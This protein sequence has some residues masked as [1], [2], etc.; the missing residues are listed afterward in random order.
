M[1]ARGSDQAAGGMTNGDSSGIDVSRSPSAR[2]MPPSARIAGAVLG[3]LDVI[4]SAINRA[5][6][7]QGLPSDDRFHAPGGIGQSGQERAAAQ[8][9]GERQRKLDADP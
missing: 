9:R 6:V 8:P 7:D 5:A 1:R 4:A 2:A 3:D